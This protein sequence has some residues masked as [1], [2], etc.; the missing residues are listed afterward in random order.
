MSIL[1]SLSIIA[2]IIV[3][4][5]VGWPA[6]ICM[7]T[8]L[9]LP[10]KDLHC[11]LEYAMQASLHVDVCQTW[12]AWPCVAPSNAAECKHVLNTVYSTAGMAAF[13]ILR[14]SANAAGRQLRNAI[15]ISYLH[16]QVINVSQAAR[17]RLAT[18]PLLSTSSP[19][20]LPSSLWLSARQSPT[21]SWHRYFS[22][23]ASK[24][25]VLTNPPKPF[26]KNGGGDD[27]TP[28]TRQQLGP[29]LFHVSE[30]TFSKENGQINLIHTHWSCNY[31]SRCCAVPD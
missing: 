27:V 15:S 24:R 6:V 23:R 25:H 8:M 22:L 30:D 19:T 17:N 11:R 12:K 14:S 28:A 1:C 16:K 26:A 2:M 18:P 21:V 10:C 5:R 7:K 20:L 13:T 31:T 29:R 3:D 4:Q 9:Q